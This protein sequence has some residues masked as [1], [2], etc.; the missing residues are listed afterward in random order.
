M[1]ALAHTHTRTL[2]ARGLR[3]IHTEL[4]RP[5]RHAGHE[6]FSMP[7]SALKDRAVPGRPVASLN[8][9]GLRVL[10]G[11][12]WSGKHTSEATTRGAFSC[13][14]TTTCRST[15]DGLAEVAEPCGSSYAREVSTMR[16]PVADCLVSARG[17]ASPGIGTPP[18][19]QRTNNT[20]H[21]VRTVVASR[22]SAGGFKP[23]SSYAL[24][25][26]HRLGEGAR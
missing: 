21:V 11:Y 26:L 18:G 7:D 24:S 9:A 17:D 1:S 12:G 15:V 13:K 8:G 25:T 4:A 14:S 5:S 16:V 2:R 22:R 20:K 6:R 10:R 19:K 23:V 3:A